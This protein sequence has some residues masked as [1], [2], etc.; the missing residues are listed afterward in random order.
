MNLSYRK[1]IWL[2]INIC[3]IREVSKTH[4]TRYI[5]GPFSEWQILLYLFAIQH[6]RDSK[7]GLLA[8]PV[9]AAEG[10]MLLVGV[11]IEYQVAAGTASDPGPD[12]W[13]LMLEYEWADFCCFHFE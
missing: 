5:F 6:V 11:G 3:I 9:P 4:S 10:L 12:A 13:Q 7:L 1:N 2:E 8:D